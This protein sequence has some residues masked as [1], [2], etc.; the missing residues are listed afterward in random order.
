MKQEQ[1]LSQ[2]RSLAELETLDEAER[3]V[4]ATFETLRERLAANEPNNLAAQL[5]GELGEYLEGGGGEDAFSVGEFY[6]RVAEKEGVGVE[7]ATTHARAVGAVLQEAVTEGE[8]DDIRQQLKPEYDE[9]FGD[10]S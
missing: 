6:D 1:F 5:P 4:Q 9:L 8:L 7:E 3:A 10:Q 2:V